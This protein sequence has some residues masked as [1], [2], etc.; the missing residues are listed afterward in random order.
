MQLVIDTGD[1][2]ETVAVT[3][4]VTETKTFTGIFF[5]PHAAGVPVR[6]A[7]AFAS[8]VV[9]TNYTCGLP[10]VNCGSTPYILKLYGDINDDGIMQYIEYYCDTTG[11]NL[12]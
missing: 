3:N 11:G 12:Y 5:I 10:P 8:G 9:P 6:V 1:K 2:E 4:L 7:G